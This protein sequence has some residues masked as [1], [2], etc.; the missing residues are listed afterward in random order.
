MAR[1]AIMALE[2]IEEPSE[3]L[4]TTPVDLTEVNEAGQDVEDT[5]DTI[6]EAQD[7]TETIGRVADVLEGTPAADAP[8]ADTRAADTRVSADVE[9]S[10]EAAEVTRVAVE[11]FM[12]RLGYKKRSMKYALESFGKSKSANKELVAEL[13]L[14]QEEINKRI[15]IAQEGLWS[16]IKHRFSLF[17][18]TVKKVSENLDAVSAAY[19]EKGAKEG[20]LGQPGYGRYLNTGN[21]D[22]VT[23][24][25]VIADVKNLQSLFTGSA[26]KA[27]LDKM[28]AVLKKSNEVGGASSEWRLLQSDIV[29]L[30]V[31]LDEKY[32][33]VKRKGGKDANFIPLQPKEKAKLVEL[34]KA[35]M[36]D[37]GFSEQIDALEDEDFGSEATD[38]IDKLAECFN[39]RI[40][41]CHAV[42]AYIKDSTAKGGKSAEAAPAAEA[43]KAE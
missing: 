23:G 41:L 13:R 37:N 30:S 12:K 34:V 19:D 24:A 36:N 22:T 29:K 4:D 40:V 43:P 18:T 25:D 5:K 31:A 3:E 38:T 2:G 35:L 14:A 1:I 10:P 28:L 42:V 6:E 32:S 8:A 20:D 39:T 16:K 17:F 9:I 11:H 27:K 15:T 21:K 7:T 33:G 26:N